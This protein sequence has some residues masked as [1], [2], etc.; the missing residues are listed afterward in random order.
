MDWEDCYQRNDTP[1]DK[2][3]PCPGL[4]TLLKTRPLSGGVLVPGCGTGHDVRALAAHPQCFPV[5]LDLSPSA[6]QRAEAFSKVGAEQYLLGD[7]F[8]LP[9]HFRGSFDAV[10]EH[11]CFCAI[12]RSRRGDYV[13]AVYSALKPQGELFAIFFLDPGLDDPESGPPF[14]VSVGEL[15]ALFLESGAFELVEEWAPIRAYPGRE[16]RE[17]MRH[18][19]AR[20]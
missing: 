14:D 20:P 8:A 17:W 6:I 5:G 12:P 15:D 13:R 16:G 19:R 1:W 10:W 2:G 4:E 18:L 3:A 9:E 7:L 11:T